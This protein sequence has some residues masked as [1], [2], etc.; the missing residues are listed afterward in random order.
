MWYFARVTFVVFIILNSSDAQP[1]NSMQ[2]QMSR[3]ERGIRSTN[4]VVKIA[5]LHSA[6]ACALFG[7]SQDNSH[8]VNYDTSRK[9]CEVI[10]MHG[11]VMEMQNSYPYVFAA[12]NNTN[13]LLATGVRDICTHGPVQWKEQ[14]TRDYMTL[15]NVVHADEAFEWNYVCKATV[16][17][18][19][20]PGVVDSSK[21]CQFVY[22]NLPSFSEL[23]RT[24]T[25]VVDNGLVSANWM[26]YTIGDEVPEEAFIGGHLSVVTPLYVCRAF[27]DGVQYIGHYN[28][29]AGL[30]YIHSGSVQ[31]PTTVSLLSFSPNGPT[32][33]GPTTDWPCPRYHVRIAS[34]QYEYIQ[35]YGSHAIPSWAVISSSS[36]A[37][38]ESA[39]VF[40]APG[41]FSDSNDKFYMVCGNTEG[42][43][44][45]GRLLKTS[46]SVQWEPF[47]AGS[48][49]PY[50]AFLASHTIENDPLYIV[51][52]TKY[53]Y[54]IGFYNPRTKSTNIQYRGVRHPA[55]VH[56]LTFSWPQGSASWS[57]ANYEAY[58][59]PITAI[60]IQHETSITGI[61]FRF[62]A[63]WSSGFWLESPAA[64][65]TEIN[66]NAREY[67]TGV[68]IGLNDTLGYLEL[69]TN[70]NTY[71][72]FGKASGYKTIS[73][74]THCGHVHHF[75]G[76]LRWDEIG[77]INKTFSFAMHG[78]SCTWN[79]CW[80]VIPRPGVF[81]VYI[82][83]CNS[84][85]CGAVKTNA[86]F[87]IWCIIW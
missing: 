38:G 83:H 2:F 30:A 85:R 14:A 39:G 37:L 36:Y 82:W 12:I 11:S 51:M 41:K 69:Y 26:S 71:G 7:I 87:Y 23:Y 54:A 84:Y 31:Y 4:G 42:A 35:H 20:I 72:P 53:R 60:R 56:I 34:L 80:N 68:K 61:K 16:G 49:V 78:D 59:G 58:S 24:L 28:P 76:Y 33:A 19:E 8:A 75:S 45:W 74:F 77:R 73:M 86:V 10:S 55:S 5:E 32:S 63:Q 46:F 9:L 48:D 6:V 27:V 57:D 13:D 50:N 47:L 65:F 44:L 67:I 29:R 43:Q 52:H 62:G 21:E 25:V 1:T 64:T 22:K 40:S 15:E 79:S 3:I 81:I 18:S 66:F 17:D 70:L